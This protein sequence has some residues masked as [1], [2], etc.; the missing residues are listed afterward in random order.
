ML[1]DLKILEEIDFNFEFYKEYNLSFKVHDN[2]LFG[3]VNNELK[4]E[5][6]DKS[7]TLNY[8]GMGLITEDGTMC[9]KEVQVS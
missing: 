3:Y 1:Y 4:I 9:T 6:Q 2:K 5:T 7:N 8:G